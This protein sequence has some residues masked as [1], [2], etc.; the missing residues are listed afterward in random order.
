VLHDVAEDDVELAVDLVH[1]LEGHPTVAPDPVG[2]AGAPEV[3]HG[4]LLVR[5]IAVGHVDL[6]ALADGSGEPVRRVSVARAKLQDP[7]GPDRSSEDLQGHPDQAVD[8]R[9][10]PLPGLLLHLVRDRVLSAQEIGQVLVHV[11]IHD[12]H[13]FLLVAERVR[14]TGGSYHA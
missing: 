5:R 14:V 4:S 3:V 1:Q 13:G 7:P 12:V 6:A 8:D 10:V 2:E 9:E 11:W